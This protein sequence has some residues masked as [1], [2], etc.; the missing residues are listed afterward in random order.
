MLRL[1]LADLVDGAGLGA[2]FPFNGRAEVDRV[3]K[4]AMDDPNPPPD[5]PD[6]APDEAPIGRDETGGRDLEA[7]DEIL[8]MSP[9]GGRSVTF[10]GDG[11]APTTADPPGEGGKGTTPTQ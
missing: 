3:R 8:R 1:D 10:V 11:G 6:P 7:F 2:R 4:L 9:D 5:E